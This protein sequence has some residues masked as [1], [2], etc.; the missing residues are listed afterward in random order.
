MNNKADMCRG[1]R[2]GPGSQ[3]TGAPGS[4][5]IAIRDS[6]PPDLVEALKDLDEA[7]EEA[8]EQEYVPP[9]ASTLVHAEAVLRKIY[10]ASSRPYIVYPMPDDE[11]AIYAPGK[12]G[13]SAVLYCFPDGSTSCRVNMQGDF[14]GMEYGPNDLLPDR[15][16][17]EVL[18]HM[19]ESWRLANDRPE[20]G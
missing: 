12:R 14:S 8:E 20:P 7:R 16:L 4:H 11:I 2:S 18:A 17:R 1:A 10:E 15:F 6:D 9:S 5:R 19:E 13:E 3:S